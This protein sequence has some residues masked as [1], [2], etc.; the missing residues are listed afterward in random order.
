MANKY[1]ASGG[2]SPKQTLRSSLRRLEKTMTRSPVSMGGPVES[3]THIFA[4]TNG[5]PKAIR[6]TAINTAKTAKQVTKKTRGR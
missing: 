4:S 2:K 5:I 6:R 3:L 1:S